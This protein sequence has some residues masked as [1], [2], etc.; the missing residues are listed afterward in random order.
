[1]RARHLLLLLS[2]L[3]CGTR[4]SVAQGNDAGTS[5]QHEYWLV[6]QRNFRDYVA[7]ARTGGQRPAD[8][9]DLELTLASPFDAH[10]TVQAGR[11]GAVVPFRI[12]A[13]QVLH[14]PIDSSMQLRSNGVVEPLSVHVA[15]S[16]PLGVYGVNRRFQTTDTYMAL[17][18][19][20]LGTE[21]RVAGFRAL[22]KDLGSQA[23]VIATEDGTSVKIV[24]TARVC[25]GGA[26]D[27]TISVTL[28]RGDVY[29]IIAID[30]GDLTG[31]SI[32][33]DKPIA[34][35]S[36]HNCAY[37]PD[38]KNKACNM[39]AEQIP[40]TSAWGRTFAAASFAERRHS[41]L[42]VIAGSRGAHVVVGS[43]APAEIPAGGFIQRD[44]TAAAAITSDEPVLAVLYSTG[45][46]LEDVGDPMMVI[47]PPVEQFV[48]ECHVAT[49]IRGA[50]H[51]YATVV[52]PNAEAAGLLRVDG[53]PV[54][55]SAFVAVPSG[56][57]LVGDLPLKEG[58]HDI[59]C[60][61][62]FGCYVYGFG[63]DENQYDAYGNNAVIMRPLDAR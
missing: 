30:E 25:A 40:P 13:G 50:W 62:P 16:V 26:A 9:L 47:L 41:V 27:A 45:C 46:D 57:F 61:V 28:N 60:T 56:A 22:M 5:A 21:Y 1:M 31:T 15:S 38:V 34:V 59:V 7:D 19:D 35:Y 43:A 39:L 20:V 49:P 12:A 52:V 44:I 2:A 51:H 42:R 37:V 63:T 29:Q 55:A 6:F 24:P 36:G 58:A 54:N 17:P 23:A 14:L 32:M 8:R 4:A 53:V 3:L 48:R 18:A 11:H 10:G 33:S